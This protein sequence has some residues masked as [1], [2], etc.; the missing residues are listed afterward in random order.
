MVWYENYFLLESVSR[1]SQ[2]HLGLR[3][4][5]YSQ[6]QGVMLVLHSGNWY[7]FWKSFKMYKFYN[8]LF[9]TVSLNRAKRSD[10]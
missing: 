7:N 4:G 9:G 6:E 5:V 1:K 3:S 8:T 10:F 2:M